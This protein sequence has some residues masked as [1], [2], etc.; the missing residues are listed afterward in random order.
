MCK[1]SKSEIAEKESVGKIIVSHTDESLLNPQSVDVRLGEW[2]FVK[3]KEDR[4]NYRK[5]LETGKTEFFTRAFAKFGTFINIK[6]SPFILDRDT[7][8]DFCLAHTEEFIG[9]RGNSKI[10][11]ELKLK[12]TMARMGGDHSLAGWI[13]E[14]YFN[15]ITLELYSHLPVLLKAGML[16]G[17]V[18]FETTV[19]DGEDYSKNGSYQSTSNFEKMKKD[20]KKEDMLPKVSNLYK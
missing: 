14:G 4:K 5:V 17:Q 16:I 3:T 13:D 15:R 8:V 1:L 12:S 18:V 20:W 2:I 6:E 10:C 11:S 9:T 19:G 7:D